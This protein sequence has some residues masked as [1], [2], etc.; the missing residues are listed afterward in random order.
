MTNYC[1]DPVMVRVDFFK[2]SGK[3]YTTEAME[4]GP[5]TGCIHTAFKESLKRAFKGSYS[6][7]E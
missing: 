3:W 4:F 6:F 1:D 7:S 2:P 5:Y